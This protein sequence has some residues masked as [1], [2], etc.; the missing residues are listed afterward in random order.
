MRKLLILFC[1]S[2]VAWKLFLHFRPA[3][4]AALTAPTLTP[5]NGALVAG[6]GH[7]LALSDNGELYGWGV[8]EDKQ[9]GLANVFAATAPMALP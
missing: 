4:P 8:N 7:T 3:L 1:F 5:V 6:G 9:L 2:F